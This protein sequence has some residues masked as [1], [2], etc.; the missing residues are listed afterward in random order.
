MKAV[1]L[2]KNQLTGEIPSNLGNLT[3]LE[4][5]ALDSNQL[6]DEIPSSLGNLKEMK[7][8]YLTKNQ[9]TGH[10]PDS[11]GDMVKLEKLYLSEN[12][13]TG[14]IPSSLGNLKEMKILYL[15]KNQLTGHIPDSMGDMVKLEDLYLNENLLTGEIPSSFGNLKALK[16]LYLFNNQLTGEILNSLGDLT[17][18]ETLRLDNNQLTGEIPNSLGNLTS[19]QTLTLNNNPLTGEIPSSLGNLTSLT[20]LNISTNQITGE[21]PT[22]LGNL[23]N[24]NTLYLVETQ[25]TGEIPSSLGNLTSLTYLNISTNQISGEIPSSLGNLVNIKILFLLETQLT[26]EIPSSLGNLTQMEDL[27]LRNN[28]L[29]GTIPDSFVN[30]TALKTLDITQNRMEGVLS[31]A[32]LK[33]DWW[34]S[35]SIDLW[36]QDGYRL[37]Y[38]W[39]YESTDFSNDRQVE[40]LQGHSKGKGI[41][42]VITGDGF[43]DR[44]VNDGTFRNRAIQAMDHFFSIEPYTSFREYFDV[45][46]VTAVSVNKVLEENTVF[47]T[48]VEDLTYILNNKIKLADYLYEVSALDYDLS[49]VTTLVILNTEATGRVTSIQYKDGFSFGLCRTKESDMRQEVCHEVGGHGFGKLLDEYSNDGHEGTAFTDRELLDYYHTIGRGLNL[50]YESDPQKVLWSDFISNPDYEVE[51][52]GV[53]EGGFARYTYGIYRPTYES[54]MRTSYI[55][56]DFNAPSRRAIYQRIMELAGGHYTFDDFLQYDKKNLQQYAASAST[57]NY[58]ERSAANVRLLGAPPIFHDYPSSEIGKH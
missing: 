20:Y 19:L 12:Q 32:L 22:S 3:H 35:R 45:Y 27:S 44:L 16:V 33:S 46:M 43:S 42:I 58:V 26:G 23:V 13:L 53:Y 15:A 31:E 17:S 34:K 4:Q 38:G 18:L 47:E 52:I 29:T 21:I 55:Y 10:I 48:R 6:T 51:K 24:L 8:L 25:L 30:L 2:G 41:K 5:L 57:R 37:K 36:Q 49:N 40:Q 1:Y 39:L 14:E 50:D 7:I 54:I 11:M 56:K 28:L 9:L